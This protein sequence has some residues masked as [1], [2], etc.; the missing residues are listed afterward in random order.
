MYD[1]ELKSK[2]IARCTECG[3]LIYDNSSEVYID[4]DGNYFCG[5]ECSLNFYGI[6]TVEDYPMGD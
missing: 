1:E 2:A 4:N 5:L 6:H 3:E